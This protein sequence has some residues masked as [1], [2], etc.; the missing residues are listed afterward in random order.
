MTEI[1]TRYKKVGRKYV[2][3]AIRWGD[4]GMD[5]MPVGT[6]RFTYAHSEGGRRFVV[7]VTP[8]TAPM[9]AAMM[10]AR[11]AMEQAITDA[12]RMR[13]QTNVY[14]TKKQLATIKKFKEEMGGMFPSWWTEGSAHEIAQAAID[15]VVN[16]KP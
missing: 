6:F 4:D 13:P 10:L 16:Y 1:E 15:D 12:A 14:Y 8:A 7:D 3:V 2:P 5:S 9:V 11:K